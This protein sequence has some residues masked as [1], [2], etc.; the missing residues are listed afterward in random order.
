MITWELRLTRTLLTSMCRAVSPSSSLMSVAG[1]TTTPA[2]MTH[3][4]CG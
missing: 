2:P 3:V 4:M 1:F